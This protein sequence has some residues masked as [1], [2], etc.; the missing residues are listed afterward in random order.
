MS[1]P[2]SDLQGIAPSSIIELYELQLNAAIHGASDVWR[3]HAGSSL[4]ANGDLI[5]AGN[6]Y[7]RFPVEAEA[8]EY[9]TSG[10]L[11]RPKLRFSNVMGTITTLLLATPHG[12]E[13]AK[14]TRI[15]TL[16]RYIDGAN[17]SGG[18]NPYGTPDSTALLPTEVFYLDRKTAETRDVVE[19]ECCAAFDLAGIRAPKRQAVSNICQW[20]YRDSTTC[21]YTGTAYFD[22]NDNPVSSLSLDVCGKRLSSCKKRF[23]GQPITGFVTSGSTT[24]TN[25]GGGSAA[26]QGRGISGPGLA[27]GTLI[28]S[29]NTTTNTLVLS[30]AALAGSSQTST[31][32]LQMPSGAQGTVLR[33]SYNSAIAVGM[34]VSGTYIPDGTTITKIVSATTINLGVV[35]GTSD[36]TLSIAWNPLVW[37]Y[38]TTAPGYYY[39]SGTT[40]TIAM[41]GSTGIAVGYLVTG[42]GVY[43]NTTVVSIA[44]VSGSYNKVLTLSKAVAANTGTF[45]GGW[46]FSSPITPGSSTYNFLAQQN[47]AVGAAVTIP[48][49]SFP[50]VGGY[51]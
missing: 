19:Y 40:Y 32:T 41:A 7:M 44:T 48:F 17:F 5:W 12:L 24:M 36:L 8:F 37:N 43:A 21:G 46:T 6:T 15:R 11:P 30:Q 28:S 13:G 16:A 25:V 31:G 29:V 39:A 22:S 1:I 45:V 23:G 10:Q 47:Y 26:Y 20:Q 49:G 9:S 34:V 35:S 18:T 51:A 4:N 33:I 27:N 42:P 14:L 2:V 38:S 50:G 3:F